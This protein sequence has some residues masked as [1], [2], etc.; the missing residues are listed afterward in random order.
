MPWSHHYLDHT[1]AWIFGHEASLCFRFRS[2][3]GCLPEA[4]ERWRGDKTP[5]CEKDPCADRLDEGSC[6]EGE[7]CFQAKRLD[8]KWCSHVH[9]SDVSAVSS[10][11]FSCFV[12]AYFFGEVVCRALWYDTC[13]FV[14]Y[15]CLRSIYEWM[16]LYI[17][18][19]EVR[20][21]QCTVLAWP[22]CGFKK[23]I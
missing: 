10:S 2:V 6:F 18:Q 5:L 3:R 17:P 1:L 11:L 7:R 14:V 8:D 4:R 22:I 9:F 19:T 20:H 12:F 23:S 13:G 16:Q 21:Q 15:I